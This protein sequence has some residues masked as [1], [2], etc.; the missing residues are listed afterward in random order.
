M[1]TSFDYE[2]YLKTLHTKELLDLLQSARECNGAYNPFY[3][4]GYALEGSK[5]YTIDEIKSELSTR[6]HIPNKAEAKR[7]RQE[8]HKQKQ[9]R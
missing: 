3:D 5:W 2:N 1:S 4:D 8:K 7:I 6:E 9:N